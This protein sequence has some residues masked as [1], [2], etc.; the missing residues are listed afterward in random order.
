MKY[1]QTEIAK[2]E[3]EFDLNLAPLILELLTILNKVFL[4]LFH[5]LT[6]EQLEGFLE[7][8]D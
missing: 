1:L 5:F 7:L 2:G 8:S 6:V 3:V 4:L